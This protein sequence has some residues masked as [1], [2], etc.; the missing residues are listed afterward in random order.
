[1]AVSFDWDA[2]IVMAPEL[3]ALSTDAQD[4]V[5]AAVNDEVDA[6]AFGTAERADR[7]GLW[8]ARHLGTMA[9]TK[10]GGGS[11]PVSSVSAGG[12]SKSFS[13]GSQLQDTL[14]LTKYGLEY[15]RLVRL[16]CPR[17]AVL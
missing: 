10:W 3:S 8:L 7:A 12:V 5:L 14:S 15:L 16:F 17:F 6:V 1:M 13:I 9:L 2:V 11:A 4:E